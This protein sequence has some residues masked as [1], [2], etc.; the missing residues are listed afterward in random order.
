MRD[1][2]LAQAHQVARSEEQ[3]VLLGDQDVIGQLQQVPLVKHV[4]LV[5]TRIPPADA[6]EGRPCNL[7]SVSPAE[8]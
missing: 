4:E 8:L 6:F 5:K 1:P 2:G 3:P 7:R